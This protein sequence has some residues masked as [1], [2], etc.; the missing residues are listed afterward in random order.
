MFICSIHFS[1]NET[2]T[3]VWK[4]LRLWLLCPLYF[5]TPCWLLNR[6]A[7]VELQFI[8]DCKTICSKQFGGSD[9][10]KGIKAVTIRP[11]GTNWLIFIFC[12][13]WSFC[14]ILFI[15][16]GIIHL[17]IWHFLARL[18]V[19][20]PV[21]IKWA[22]NWISA[23]K[24][25]KTSSNSLTCPSPNKIIGKLFLKYFIGNYFVKLFFRFAL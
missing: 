13:H 23:N 19:F 25:G 10:G 16:Y 3:G 22:N 14:T 2:I 15:G 6:L 5:C 18:E 21:I 11:F 8:C 9:Q 1:Y 20:F 12:E 7:Q 17:G 24:E 4:L